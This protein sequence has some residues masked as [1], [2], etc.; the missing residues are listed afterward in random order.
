MVFINENTNVLEGKFEYWQEVLEKN[1]L[2]RSRAKT[3][4]LEFRFNNKI[5]G[6]END[7]N[8]TFG[9]R[10][11]NKVGKFKSIRINLVREWGNCGRCS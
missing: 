5:R 11:F 8:L 7:H 6:N 1:E 3:E 2:K 9:G 4:Y 10:R